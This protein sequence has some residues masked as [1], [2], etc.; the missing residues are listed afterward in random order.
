MSATSSINLARRHPL[1]TV[2]YIINF[3]SS[4]LINEMDVKLFYSGFETCFEPST[5]RVLGC[6]LHR[7]ARYLAM[8]ERGGD[9]IMC[10]PTIV[11]ITCAVLATC[12]ALAPVAGSAHVTGMPLATS[13]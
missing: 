13:E 2:D 11:L 7:K 5:A 3:H 6:K 12:R 9:V 1:A 8:F 4:Q 10:A